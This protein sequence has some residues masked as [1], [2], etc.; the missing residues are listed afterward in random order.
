M[1]SFFKFTVFTFFLLIVTQGIGQPGGGGTKPCPRPPCPPAPISG[2]EVLIGLGGLYG[3]K[4]LFNNSK[5][6]VK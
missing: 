4:R 1:K 5:N 3:A 6:K 2:I